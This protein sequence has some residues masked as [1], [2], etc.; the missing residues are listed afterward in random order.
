MHHFY[1]A[2][3]CFSVIT[4]IIVLPIEARNSWHPSTFH[5]RTLT[6]VLTEDSWLTLV[7]TS[8]RMPVNASPASGW[9]SSLDKAPRVGIGIPE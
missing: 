5:K 9:S 4:H 8:L 1:S 2:R 6:V 3:M 7:F